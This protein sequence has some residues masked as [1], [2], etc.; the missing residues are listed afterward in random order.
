MGQRHPRV[1]RL[2]LGASDRL[3]RRGGQL[4]F[5]S[6][7]LAATAAALTK[8]RNFS[9]FSNTNIEV[10]DPSALTATRAIATAKPISGREG[11]FPKPEICDATSQIL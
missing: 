5:G 2:G 4:C 6:L 7:V 9:D 11:P 3:M 10:G 1:G 8:R